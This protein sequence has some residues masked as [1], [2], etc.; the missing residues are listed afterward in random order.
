MGIECD[1]MC[2]VETEWDDEGLSDGEADPVREW[3]CE[4]EGMSDRDLE[5]DTGFERDCDCDIVC[6]GRHGRVIV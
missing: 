4:V 1:S 5:C 6:S 3:D 2:D